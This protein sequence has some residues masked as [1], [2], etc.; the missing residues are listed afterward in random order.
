MRTFA[1]PI[2]VETV[3]DRLKDRRRTA[4]LDGRRQD[5]QVRTLEQGVYLPH[6]VVYDATA[7]LPASQTAVA[8]TD[9]H[10]IRTQDV[11]VPSVGGQGPL[12]TLAH[13]IGETFPVTAP[14]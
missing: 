2:R 5:Q 4:E 7:V 12:R 13:R 8:V 14:A 9:I 1:V 11:D 3:D 6:I 10:V